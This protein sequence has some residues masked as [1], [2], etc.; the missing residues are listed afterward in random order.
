MDG[1][2]VG[3]LDGNNGYIHGKIAIGPLTDVFYTVVVVDNGGSGELLP[4]TV[5]L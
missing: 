2:A 4:W 5:E 1:R 3:P